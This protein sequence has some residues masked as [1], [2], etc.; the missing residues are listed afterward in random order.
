M[1]EIRH[2]KASDS[3]ECEL[4]DDT[5]LWRYVPLKTLFVYLSGKVFI[6]SIE[7]LRKLDPFEGEFYY[8]SHPALFNGAIETWHG[9]DGADEMRE[10][11]FEHKFPAALQKHIRP[12]PGNRASTNLD[13]PS[14][15]QTY[16]E[17]LR[18]TRCAWCWFDGGENIES[19]AMW[20]LYGKAGAMI[21]TSVGQLRNA[22]GASQRDFEY[23]R[24]RYI[25]IGRFGSVL[26]HDALHPE[27]D[28]FYSELMLRPHFLKRAEYR[29]EQEVRFV[30]SNS[31]PVAGVE[32]HI[33]PAKWIGRILLYPGLERT[34]VAAI[35]S[36]A[37]TKEIQCVQSELLGKAI[38]DPNSTLADLL[39]SPIP[40]AL[41]RLWRK[42]AS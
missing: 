7:T 10:W 22:L 19:A 29:S 4:P 6:P 27:A 3:A 38:P 15:R 11:L 1:N 40:E 32:L 5:H 24:M 18:S 21:M 14:Y 20:N 26:D 39:T 17:I 8:D 37:E 9:K 36:I 2:F 34:E 28:S 13:S 41:Q 23:S 25:P 16:F 30:T 12:E 33:P 42:S 35:K 31:K